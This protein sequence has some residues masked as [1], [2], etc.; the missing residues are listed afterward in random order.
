MAA[1]FFTATLIFLY[2]SLDFFTFENF[3][4][5]DSS[6]AN[7]KLAVLSF[8]LGVGL[9]NFREYHFDFDENRYKILFCVGLV[10]VGKWKPFENLEYISVFR[11]NARS[12]FEINLW[13][14]RNKHFNISMYFKKEE[15][16]R[17]G[18]EIAKKLNIPIL[19]ATDPYNSK[20]I[21]E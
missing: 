15:A 11:N 9:S 3:H 7:V 2:N 10:K 14:N 20:W 13:Y 17:M 4:M 19:D 12:V 1:I 18:K 8:S 21:T 5:M 16:L 6:M